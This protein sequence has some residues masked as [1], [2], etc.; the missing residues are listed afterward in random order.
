MIPM[1]VKNI[2]LANSRKYKFA[3]IISF[4][5]GTLI[6]TIPHTFKFIKHYKMETLIKKEIKL[7]L[8]KS[9]E[10]CKDKN[11][12]YAKFVNLGFPETAISKFNVCMQENRANFKN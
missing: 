11:S 2:L 4:I 7:Q 10:K 6:A 8:K 12:D 5:I 1:L 9:E 3:F